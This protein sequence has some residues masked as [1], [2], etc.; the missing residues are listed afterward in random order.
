[1][2][3]AAPQWVEAIWPREHASRSENASAPADAERGTPAAL[4]D[5]GKAV[6]PPAR[7]QM[8]ENEIAKSEQAMRRESSW[9]IPWNEGL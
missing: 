8:M 9:H 2:I 6:M 5:S 1:V 3:N 4:S 7:M